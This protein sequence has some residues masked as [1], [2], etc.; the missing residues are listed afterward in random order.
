[1]RILASLL[2]LQAQILI[3]VL[4]NTTASIPEKDIYI[5]GLFAKQGVWPWGHALIPAAEMVLEEINNHS[6]LLPGYR[7]QMLLDDTKVCYL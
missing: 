1:M 6:S 5:L 2:V 7:L 3:L 4:V